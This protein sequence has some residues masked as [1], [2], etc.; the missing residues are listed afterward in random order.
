MQRVSRITCDTKDQRGSNKIVEQEGDW[1]KET[2]DIFETIK[3]QNAVYARDAEY[4]REYLQ[5]GDIVRTEVYHISTE[6]REV[7]HN[8]F[9]T[10]EVEILAKYKH[11]AITSKGTATWNEIA[12]HNKHLLRRGR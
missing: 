7:E 4:L 5:V 3:A 10:E 2:R 1:M 8:A 12:I 6:S 9:G 11:F